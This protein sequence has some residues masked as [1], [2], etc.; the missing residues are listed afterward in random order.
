MAQFCTLPNLY[1]VC[2][3]FWIDHQRIN[4][5][6]YI[7]NQLLLTQIHELIEAFSYLRQ[8]NIAYFERHIHEPE[9][10]ETLITGDTVMRYSS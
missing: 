1:F 9:F 10:L 7:E 6:I 8:V 4:L 3:I 5:W 2:V